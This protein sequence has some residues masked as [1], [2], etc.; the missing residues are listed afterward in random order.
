MLNLL[1]VFMKEGRTA[2]VNEGKVP[3]NMYD[4]LL[5]LASS[6]LAEVWLISRFNPFIHLLKLTKNR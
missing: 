5:N 4:R 1:T 3:V 2:N 6:A